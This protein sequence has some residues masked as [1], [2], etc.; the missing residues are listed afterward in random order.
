MLRVA[1][2][3]ALKN[4]I[5]PIGRNSISRFASILYRKDGLQFCGLNSYRTHPLQAKFGINE[6]SVHI[7]SEISA[8]VQATRWLARRAG[9]SYNSVDDLSEFSLAVARV[10]KN[11]TVAMAKPCSGCQRAIIAYNI[12]EVEWTE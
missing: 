5:L 6:E 12:K 7:H 2:T 9:K 11:G 3:E 10:L 4:P 1:I 8:I